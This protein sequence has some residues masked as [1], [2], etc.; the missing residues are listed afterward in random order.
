MKSFN[1]YRLIP[2]I[3]TL[4]MMIGC[5]DLYDERADTE[6]NEDQVFKTYDRMIKLGYNIYNYLPE[7]YHSVDGSYLAG[8]TD[9]GEHTWEE[10]DIRLFNEG[11]WSQ[12]KN[13][14]DRWEKMYSGIRASNLFLENS[15][16]FNAFI[17]ADTFTPTDRFTY[18]R[19]I[20]D[21]EFMRA[22]VRFLRAYFHF[23]L[24]CRYGGVP[25]VTE[26]LD[27][28]EGTEITR[29]S[30]QE[31]I[32]FI[33][34]ECDSVKDLV[35]PTFQFFDNTREGRVTTGVVLALKSRA[36]LYAASPLHNPEGDPIKWQKAAE[37]ARVVI[38]M[39][40]YSL[41]PDY[42]AL[43]L[44]PKSY[45]SPEVIWSRRYGESNFVERANYPIGTDGGMSGTC[46]SHNLVS[47]YEKL[48][49]WDPTFPYQ[50]RDP[51]LQASIVVNGS[52]WNGRTMEIWT[53]GRDAPASG[54]GGATRTGYY[55]K[56]FLVDNLDL[57]RDQTTIHS[58]IYFRYA[59]ILLNY[60]ESVNEGFDFGIRPVG[61]PLTALEAL[62]LVRS[63]S[64]M[65]GVTASGREE[66]R[67]LIHQER[68]I[69]LAFEGHRQWD[70]RRW[71][72]AGTF[73]N[74]P[75][76]AMRITRLTDS[77][78]S[79]SEEVLED[80]VFT[81]KMYLYP[82]PQEELI[83]YEAGMSQNPGW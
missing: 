19:H 42:R 53:G 69:E 37:A 51:R 29:S 26:V 56:K 44:P 50:K 27:P 4:T 45:R 76:L 24:A 1:I 74:E 6:L 83:K 14:D 59:E 35:P 67:E 5:E 57:S 2:V 61:Y 25:I 38:D 31:C 82:I 15:R 11:T 23:E 41:D 13:P 12:F 52:Q 75:L 28:G 77:T 9:D 63:R 72:K 3:L 16:D 21:M 60:A 22:E 47:A 81:D 30:F 66:L 18:Q 8:A 48:E 78:F 70:L 32:R 17:V 68:R 43:F 34:N 49:G 58:W 71:L 79:Y 80:R 20:A 54:I 62:N 40:L 7:G 73:L 39:G 65:P 10:S 46:P 64:S 33:Q 55:L 36:L